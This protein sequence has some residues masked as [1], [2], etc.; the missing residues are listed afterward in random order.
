MIKSNFL[1]IFFVLFLSLFISL[2]IVE[3]FLRI[4]I[5][6]Y[7]PKKVFHFDAKYLVWDHKIK[8][9]SHLRPSKSISTNGYFK[10]YI[11]IDKNGFRVNN[12]DEIK[13][14][15]KIITFGDSQTFGHALPNEET[16]PNLLSNISSYE[17]GNFGMWGYSIY[18][19][20]EIINRINLNYNPDFVIYG[21]TD[22]DL[23][24]TKDISKNTYD[25]KLRNFENFDKQN[26][27]KLLLIDPKGFFVHYTAIGML[28]FDFYTINLKNIFSN[29]TSKKYEKENCSK[30]LYNWLKI[31]SKKFMEKNIRFIILSLPH[32]NRIIA[33]SKNINYQNLST[34][35]LKNLN[36]IIQNQD[37]TL[38]DPINDLSMY[39]KSKNYDK[40][41]I[42]VKSD[43]HY[44]K[45]ANEILAS[46]VYKK[47]VLD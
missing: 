14:N 4:Y 28:F 39:V 34:E 46:L 8:A 42:I 37:L 11:Y 24:T 10:E 47:I 7:V 18:N 25:I 23:C 22:N 20:N 30:D 38:I 21:M 1:K 19:Y 27:F 35:I 17:V 15:P 32:P 5:Y 13:I 29:V 43:P 45:E 9:H 33:S 2:I 6:K 31:Q 44:N 26:K 36:D 16:W 40:Y 41:S 3:I 12:N